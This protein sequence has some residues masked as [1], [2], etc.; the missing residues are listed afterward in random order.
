MGGFHHVDLINRVHCPEDS[1]DAVFEEMK[2]LLTSL[3]DG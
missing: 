2:P 3:L 1:Q